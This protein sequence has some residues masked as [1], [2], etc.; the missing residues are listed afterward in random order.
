ME[1]DKGG[2]AE[3]EEANN[4]GGGEKCAPPLKWLKTHRIGL[5]FHQK[6]EKGKKPQEN[7]MKRYQQWSCSDG[8][9]N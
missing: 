5:N 1:I 7:T 6:L 8:Q 3:I 4:S 2:K 9:N